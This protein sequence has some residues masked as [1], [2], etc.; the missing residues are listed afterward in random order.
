MSGRGDSSGGNLE[1]G[2]RHYPDGEGRFQNFRRPVSTP[3]TVGG[4]DYSPLSR[5][6]LLRRIGV[7]VIQKGLARYE[8][9]F[10]QRS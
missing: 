2:G 1:T 10:T 3:T 6:L 4:P 8:G 5:L 7:T 9:L